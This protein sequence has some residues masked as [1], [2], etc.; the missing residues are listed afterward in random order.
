MIETVTPMHTPPKE[1]L[2]TFDTHTPYLAFRVTQLRQEI[3]RRGLDQQINLRVLLLAANEGTYQWEAGDWSQL[4]GGVPVTVLSEKWRHQS[5]KAFLTP[6]V[7]A[8]CYK[9]AKEYLRQKPKVAFVG[10]YDRPESVTMALLSI[11]TRG[12][13]GPLHDSRFNDAE[14][15]SKNLWL[16]FAKGMV[17]RRY[18][19][20]MCSGQEC[21]EY[22]QFLGGN[23]KPAYKGAWDVVDNAT[24]AALAEKTDQDAA[25]L[26]HLGIQPGRAFFFMPIRFLEKKNAPM[27][28]DAYARYHHQCVED[29]VK[30]AQLA[31]CG[32]GPLKDGLQDQINYHRLDGEI[33]LNPWLKY[34]EV[35]RANRLSI[36]LVLASTHDQWGMTIN[37]ALAAGAPVLCSSRAGA[38][39][40]VQNAI[41]GFTFHPWHLDHLSALFSHV[42]HTPGLVDKLRSKA[43]SSVQAF[44]IDQ[45]LQACFAVFEKYG[46]VAAQQPDRSV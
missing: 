3:S 36:G 28:I 10:G 22:S 15:Y 30:P 20:F 11:F 31:I 9:V 41:N 1:I 27:V 19:F 14:S 45:F 24:I 46:V 13:V 16:E 42:A 34:D 5:L 39:E 7:W 17:M 43:A 32:Q 33:T 29:R 8:N 37:E 12:K 2:I 40:I 6:S 38:H 23:R 35:P 18:D 26:K 25:I 4:Y 44:S 21:A